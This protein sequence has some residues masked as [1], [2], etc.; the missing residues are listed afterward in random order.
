MNGL[1]AA[2]GPTVLLW[3]TLRAQLRERPRLHDVLFQADELGNRSVA[4]VVTGLAFFGMVMVTIAHGQARRFTGNLTVV[5]PAYFELLVR[6]FGPMVA[7]LL[8]AA[9][10]GA[11]NSAELSTMKVSEQIEALQLAAGD[12]LVDLVAP[13]LWGSLLAVPALAILGTGAAALSAAL[14]AQLAFSVDGS[15][16]LDPRYVDWGDLLCAG[17][18]IFLCGAYIPLAAAWHALSARGGAEA[19]GEA[20]TAGVVSACLGSLVIDL[21][22]AV[23]FY[24]L[25]I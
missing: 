5:G 15:A 23:S 22:V 19:V 21:V 11:A 9:R 24:L 2:G 4:L 25:G 1:R 12:P 6:E 14:T 13:R 16:F 3:R 7:A 10:I 18:K 17:T 8:A 20:T